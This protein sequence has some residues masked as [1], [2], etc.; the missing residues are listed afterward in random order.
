MTNLADMISVSDDRYL[1]AIYQISHAEKAVRTKITDLAY[2]LDV[3]P[4]TA[5]GQ[6]KKLRRAKLVSYTKAHGIQLTN[7]GLKEAMKVIRKHRIWETF[8]HRVCKFGWAELHELAEQLQ[9]VRSEALIDR[10]FVLSGEP[11]FD[12]HGDPIPGRDGV[13]PVSERRPLA[14]SVEGCRCTVL[15]VIED[16]SEFLNY[17]NDLR[18]GI[19][20][21]LTVERIFEFDGSLK[22][23][24]RQNASAVLSARAAEK[25]LV[26]CARPACGCKKAGN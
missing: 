21:R 26:T 5:L 14:K 18:I 9:A 8:L 11:K 16:S 17:L 2:Y 7:A 4:P 13:L 20:D 1:K 22:I 10:I 23:R 6:V 25:I 15:G 3:K 24:Y 19:N 12:P